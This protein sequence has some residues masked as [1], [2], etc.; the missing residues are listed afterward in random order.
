MRSGDR[1]EVVAVLP[2]IPRRGVA[3]YGQ[4]SLS[5]W[6]GSASSSPLSL[7]GKSVGRALFVALPDSLTTQGKGKLPIRDL[8]IAAGL[9]APVRRAE[10]PTRMDVPPTTGH[11]D[12]T[13]QCGVDQ[14]P[15]VVRRTTVSG[16][17]PVPTIAPPGPMA[18]VRGLPA[19]YGR[20]EHRSGRRRRDGAGV[21]SAAAGAGC[22]GRCPGMGADDRQ[23]PARCGVGRSGGGG[24]MAAAAAP[25]AAGAGAGAHRRICRDPG[26]HRRLVVAAGP[27]GAVG[28]GTALG[29][30]EVPA[31]RSGGRGLVRDAGRGAGSA[32]RRAGDG[33]VDTA[34]LQIRD[35]PPSG[36]SPADR[37]T[38]AAV[39]QAR[40]GAVPC[41]RGPA[42][43][44]AAV[45][46][47]GG[48]F[49]PTVGGSVRAH[50]PGHRRYLPPAGAVGAR[51]QGSQ[52]DGLLDGAVG[53]GGQRGH[54][55]ALA[56]AAAA[57][58]LPGPDARRQT[59][60]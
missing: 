44:P 32:R 35:R 40:R 9:G 20:A 42:G 53:P 24:V 17:R 33:A 22:A 8:A 28:Q 43:R 4:R 52:P 11:P 41:H 12:G 58:R 54:R 57:G 56:A 1:T 15:L 2:V 7:G 18:R 6:L 49:C 27:L 46:G 34:E 59:S 45:D 55:A 51:R 14:A 16:S 37:G 39:G 25:A 5:W 19:G 50:H 21:R 26:R 10:R 38:F 3:A 31:G 47:R 48:R 13:R 29:C 30:V 36:G 23:G 60:R